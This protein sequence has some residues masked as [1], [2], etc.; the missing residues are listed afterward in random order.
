[1][2]CVWNRMCKA[3]WFLGLGP[4]C[5]SW[6]AKEVGGW[7]TVVEDWERDIMAVSCWG[8]RSSVQVQRRGPSLS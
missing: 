2:P 1:M 5:C 3:V 7:W 4:I 6:D 8:M